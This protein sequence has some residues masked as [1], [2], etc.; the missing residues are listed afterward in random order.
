ML[1]ALAAAWLV[2]D[3]ARNYDRGRAAMSAQQY[4][5]AAEDFAAAR[6]LTIWYRD[7]A[8]LQLRAQRALEQESAQAAASRQVRAQ[9]AGLLRR[10]GVGLAAHQEGAV[11]VALA[12]ARRLVPQGPLAAAGDQ[13]P[14]HALAVALVAHGKRALRAGHWHTAGRLAAALRLLAPGAHA[15]RLL[16]ARSR[17]AA[18]LQAQLAAARAA[19]HRHHWHRALRLARRTLRRWPG[20]PGAAA[21]VAE[22]RAALKPKPKHKTAA[23]RRRATARRRRRGGGHAGRHA[24]RGALAGAQPKPTPAPPPGAS[25]TPPPP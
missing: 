5:T 9:V 23:K 12:Q 6:V 25:S 21:V 3:A 14:A 24:H 13:G 16:A 22:A 1:L 7:A 8:G 11:V 4:G 10:A 17:E 19:A 18:A 15:G 2:T 20:F